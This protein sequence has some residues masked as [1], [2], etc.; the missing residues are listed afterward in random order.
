MAFGRWLTVK[1]KVNV[2]LVLQIENV[3]CGAASL[4]MVLRYFGKK[5][6]SLEQ[7]RTDCNVSRD[8][9]TAKGIKIAAIKN[10]LRCMAFK[11]TPKSVKSVSLPAVIHWNMGH[12]VVL[13]GYSKNCFYINDPAFGKY[14]VSCDEF[15][16]SFTGIV[17]TFEKSGE[18]LSCKDKNRYRGFTSSSI[19]PFIPKMI[20]VSFVLMTVT[21]FSMLLPFF[22]SVYIDNILLTGNIGNFNTLIATMSV[23]ILLSSIST[24]LVSK[25]SYE[26]VFIRRVL[27]YKSPCIRVNSCYRNL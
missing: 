26:C 21:V 3:E 11:A 4:A 18:F 15:D 8:G 24:I 23:V 20:L 10:G 9:V 19:K 5:N 27:F 13:C 7:L 2:P 6:I 14:R 25:L 1:N 17:L 16:R 22:N 12:F